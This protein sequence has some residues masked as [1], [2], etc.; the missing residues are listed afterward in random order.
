MKSNNMPLRGNN[1]KLLYNEQCKSTIL[2]E[3]SEFI[4]IGN[5]ANTADI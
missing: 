4:R 2:L 3:Q 1:T 5:S